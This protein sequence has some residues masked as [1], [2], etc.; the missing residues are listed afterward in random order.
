[1]SKGEHQSHQTIVR[2][3]SARAARSSRV[4]SASSSR[5]RPAAVF[6]R[7]K[8]ASERYVH[9]LARLFQ[10]IPTSIRAP[11]LQILDAMSMLLSGLVC[12]GH[13]ALRPAVNLPLEPFQLL[14]E[15]W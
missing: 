9:G 8:R 2:V 12:G 6:C 15:G 13:G 5:L 11:T 4:C 14:L 10:S 7:G 3:S 1:M